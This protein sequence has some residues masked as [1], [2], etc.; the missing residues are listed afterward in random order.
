MLT[1]QPGKAVE[2]T[3]GFQVPLVLAMPSIFKPRV[4][5]PR[6]GQ[7][8]TDNSGPPRFEAHF[9]FTPNHPDLPAVWEAALA[10]AEANW[11]GVVT[12]GPDGNVTN[13]LRTKGMFSWCV[14]SGAEYADQSNP[15][16]KREEFRP[17]AL[18]LKAGAAADRAPAIAIK[19]AEGVFDVPN[20]STRSQYESYFFGGQHVYVRV[21]I[22]PRKQGGA[23]VTCYLNGI[24]SFGTGERNDKLGGAGGQQSMSSVFARQAGGGV[25]G[26][27]HAAGTPLVQP[28]AGFGINY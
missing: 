21:A 18:K 20:D 23:G 22:A 28:V 3:L 14:M 9:L 4:Y 2:L 10:V 26:T 12:R 19:T 25:A 7:P 5:T 1:V 16:G 11:Q 13:L 17:Y 27:V 24:M 15:P 6:P 8:A